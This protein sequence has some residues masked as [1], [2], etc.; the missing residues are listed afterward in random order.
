MLSFGIDFMCQFLRR[1]EV[2][3]WLRKCGSSKMPNRASHVDS[4]TVKEE[5]RENGFQCVCMWAWEGYV[6]LEVYR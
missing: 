2:L 1:K 4:A 6:D 5:G 3:E